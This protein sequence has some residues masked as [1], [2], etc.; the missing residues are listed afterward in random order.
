MGRNASFERVDFNTMPDDRTLGPTV[1]ASCRASGEK[2]AAMQRYLN[3]IESWF[4]GV[5]LVALTCMLVIVATDI[6]GSKLFSTPV[7]GAMD[8]VSLLGVLVIGFSMP[9]SYRKGRHIKIDFVTNLMPLGLR[10]VVRSF[11]LILC[12]VFFALI[13]WRMFLYA[14]DLW[15]HGEKSLTVKISVFPFVYA[16]SV[17]FVPLLVIVPVQLLNLWKGSKK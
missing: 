10:K 14:H 16:L 3:K 11:S 15:I 8:L 1:K 9:Q 7:P 12:Q 6:V 4:S 2:M 17:A 5:A 13:V